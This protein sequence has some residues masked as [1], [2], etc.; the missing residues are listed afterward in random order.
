MQFTFTE[1][2]IIHLHWNCINNFCCVIVALLKWTGDSSSQHGESK[3]WNEVL[4]NA[5]LI[6]M[7]K[8]T[9]CKCLMFIRRDLEG[10]LFCSRCGACDPLEA[11]LRLLLVLPANIITSRS[12][13]VRFSMLVCANASWLVV[14]CR[15]FN[16]VIWHLLVVWFT[17]F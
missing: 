8:G 9:T 5:S 6:K 1:V 17:Q 13:A 2:Y 7:K 16:W 4:F 11:W 10:F 15:R 12:D 3:C 14:N